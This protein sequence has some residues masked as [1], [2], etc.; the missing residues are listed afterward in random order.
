MDFVRLLI[1]L[2]E[3]SHINLK[4][5]CSFENPKRTSMEQDRFGNRSGAGISPEPHRIA[6]S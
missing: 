2:E 4:A 1:K 3:G 5:S 6:F